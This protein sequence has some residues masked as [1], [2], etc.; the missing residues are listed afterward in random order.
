VHVRLN[1]VEDLYVVCV[2]CVALTEDQALVKDLGLYVIRRRSP[3]FGVFRRLSLY[4]EIFTNT[5]NS[6]KSLKGNFCDLN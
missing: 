1:S 2:T 5:E 3:C 4:F 6:R